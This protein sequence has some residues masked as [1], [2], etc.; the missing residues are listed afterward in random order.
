MVSYSDDKVFS[1]VKTIEEGS[2]LRLFFDCEEHEFVDNISGDGDGAGVQTTR[3]G[4]KC[5]NVDVS[6]PFTYSRIVSAIILDKYSADSRDAIFAN[7]EK[8]KDETSEI[9]DEKRKE[10]IKEYYDY[11]TWRDHAKE[12]ANEVTFTI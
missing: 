2:L 5:E 8:A 6:A 1:G 12:I 3:I 11:Q 10:Y 7:Y 9:T 4:S